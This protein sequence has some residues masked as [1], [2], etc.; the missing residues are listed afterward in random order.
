[1]VTAGRDRYIEDRLVTRRNIFFQNVSELYYII[2]ILPELCLGGQ[3]MFVLSAG[4]EGGPS[5][6]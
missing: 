3:W 2:M 1:M 4:G 6:F 5:L